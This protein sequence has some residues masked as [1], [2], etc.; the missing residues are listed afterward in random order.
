[1][2]SRFDRTSACDSRTDRQT[3]RTSALMSVS[4]VR[5]QTPANTARPRTRASVSLDLPVYSLAFAVTQCAYPRRKP[6]GM[7]QAELT[8]AAVFAPRWFTRPKIITHPGTNRARRRVTTLIETNAL[9][10]SQ[11]ATRYQYNNTIYHV[12]ILVICIALLMSLSRRSSEP[13]ERDGGPE[14]DDIGCRFTQSQLRHGDGRSPNSLCRRRCQINGE[15]VSHAP[16]QFDAFHARRR[17]S[18]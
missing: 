12:L 1:M 10:L 18:H 15:A 3:S 4:L 8:W 11:T 14:F 13:C 5:S 17:R 7:A 16:G 9:P 6:G 2:F